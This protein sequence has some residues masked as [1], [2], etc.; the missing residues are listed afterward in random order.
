MKIARVFPTKT[1]MSPMDKDAYFDSPDLFVPEYSE[2]H[3]SVAFTW[4]IEKAN[5]L[6]RQWERIA[7]VKIGGPA[8]DGEPI[9]RFKAGL[10]LRKGITIT[11]RGCPFKCPWCLVNQDLI[12]LDDFSEG[13]IIQDNNLLACSK[14]HLNKVFQMLSHQKRINFSGGL[15]SRLLKDWHINVL[16]NLSIYHLWLSF[17][18]INREKQ[19]I[20]MVEKMKP[21]F[22]RN[23][24]RCYVLIGFDGD[25]F[26]DAEG[27]LWFVYDLGL[28]PFA[29]LYRNQLG[30]YPKPEKEWRR[31]QRK[32]CR[33]AIIKSNIQ[34]FREEE[35][36]LLSILQH[37]PCK[38]QGKD[39]K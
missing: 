22:S 36:T 2:I 10:Y 33:P 15:D 11:S 34:K 13:N 28:L 4:D 30:E 26:D 19:L 12:E 9:D 37:K 6:K 38:S 21:Y 25:S 17:D 18:D 29:M 27:R 8:I 24:L 14:T 5:Y 16:R 3:V 23:Q 7:P 20:R 35:I 39:K 1:S 32:W 31:F